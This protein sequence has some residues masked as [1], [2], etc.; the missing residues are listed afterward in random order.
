MLEL[1]VFHRKEILFQG[2][3]LDIHFGRVEREARKMRREARK[4]HQ[5]MEETGADYELA[6]KATRFI[7]RIGGEE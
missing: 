5:Y 4:T 6:R 1:A 7:D 3:E 2:D